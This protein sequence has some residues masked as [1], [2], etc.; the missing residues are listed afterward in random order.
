LHRISYCID[1]SGIP[2][3]EAAASALI[4]RMKTL[5]DGHPN[6]EPAQLTYKKSAVLRPAIWKILLHNLQRIVMAIRSQKLG[7]ARL[8]NR[9]R[10]VFYIPP[11]L[12]VDGVSIQ[13]NRECITN[14]RIDAD[15]PESSFLPKFGRAVQDLWAEDI[16][17]ML[18]D[19][20][21]CLSVDEKAA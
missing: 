6:D 21:S 20:P 14:H 3:S 15:S 1:L 13:E 4:M 7:P 16:I 19:R 10:F 9:V 2:E 5:H 18:L 8:S 12:S 11:S 17:H